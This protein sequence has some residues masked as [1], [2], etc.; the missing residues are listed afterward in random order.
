MAI[1]V[2]FPDS[3]INGEIFT[4]PNNGFT[5]QYVTG[6]GWVQYTA[7]I[8]QPPF[9]GTPT[10]I[11]VGSEPVN[12]IP[13]IVWFPTGP[14]T[15]GIGYIW[16]GS[17]WAIINA[18]RVNSG[19]ISERPSGP[20][21]GDLFF[22]TG[23]QVMELWD[24][25]SWIGVPTTVDAT[26]VTFA[27]GTGLVSS[28]VK[29]AIDEVDTKVN[30]LNTSLVY[31]GTYN[32]STN[33]VSSVTVGGTTA[34]LSTG[35]PL[36]SSAPNTF[37]IV[38]VD[39]I[40]TVPAPT[41]ALVAGN[42]LVNNGTSWDV[43]QF[44]DPV[45]SANLVTFTPTTGVGSTNVQAAVE[46]LDS[47]KADKSISIQAGTGLVGG[48]DLSA[49]STISLENTSVSSGSYGGQDKTI[50]IDVDPQGRLNS[51]NQVNLQPAT[52]FQAGIVQLDNSTTSV[53]ETTSP[54]SKALS[55]TKTVADAAL[56]QSVVNDGD[57]GDLASLVTTD[58]STIVNAINEVQIEADTA[59]STANQGV[60]DASAAQT[61][62]N[63]ADAKASTNEANIGTLGNL[64]TTDKSNVVNAINELDSGKAE[65]SR[66]VISGT[67][68]TGG[69]DLT[70]DR[71]LSLD[72][73]G[74]TAGT[75][76]NDGI[77]PQVQVDAYGR[78]TNISDISATLD[79][80]SNVSVAAPTDGQALVWGNANSQW[81]P[82]T[83]SNSI[84]T[85]T[86][87]ELN[88]A[89]SFIT[90]RWSTVAIVANNNSADVQGEATIFSSGDQ[91]LVYVTDSDGS[92]FK[93]DWD[94]AVAANGGSTF[95]LTFYVSRD[96]G[97]NWTTHTSGNSIYQSSFNNIQ[98]NTCN[99]DLSLNTNELSISF[100]NPSLPPT[101][102]ANG[103]ILRYVAAESV[104]KPAVLPNVNTTESNLIYVDAD[105]GN[106]TTGSVGDITL[107]YATI[108]AAL[109]AATSTS[110][111][112]VSE[113]TYN[114]ANPL[115][116]PAGVQIIS[117][118]GTL[119]WVNTIVDAT[120]TSDDVFILQGNGAGICGL[121][122]RVP[123]AANKA[124]ISY[125]GGSGTTASVTFT[126]FYGRAIS[127]G[128]AILVNS[129]GS[130]KIISFENRYRGL[131]M[132]CMMQVNGGIL[133]NESV[134]IPNTPLGGG[135]RTVFKN[136][137][138][139]GSTISRLQ[140]NTSNTGNSNVQHCLEVDGGTSVF[141]GINWFNAANG[142]HI[143]SDTYDVEISNGLCDTTTSVT[144]DAG[145]T[146]DSGRLVIF[147]FMNNEF[148][149]PNTWA[150]SDF[151][152]EFLTKINDPKIPEKSK[153]LRGADLSI[154]STT[155][156]GGITVGSGPVHKNGLIVLTSDN[157]A[158]STSDGG[159][160][161]NVTNEALSKDGSLFTFQGVGANHCIYFGS[162]E[163]SG[164]GSFIKHFGL[165]IEINSGDSRDGNYIFEIWDGAQ[166]ASFGAQSVGGES[167]FSYA[168]SHF[169]RNTS[170]E[171]VFYGLRPEDSWAVKAINGSN[172]Y[173]SRV[174]I[175]T[176]P[177][178]V[179]TFEQTFLI[180][181]ASLKVSK[182]G[183]IT[184]L[185][186][187]QPLTVLA[188]GSNIFSENGNVTDFTFTMGDGANSYDHTIDN[189]VLNAVGEGL[190]W[191]TTIAPG[192]CTAH[193]LYVDVRYSLS[194]VT[195]T[196]PE[197]RVYFAPIQTSGILIADPAGSLTPIPRP[198]SLTVPFTGAGAANPNLI[199]NFVA[200]YVLPDK[201]HRARLGPF[202]IENY[203]EGDE[204]ALEIE[205]E[206]RGSPQT[207]FIIWGVSVVGYQW[208]TGIR[209]E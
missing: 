163:L 208:T 137:N 133:A 148:S 154:G 85:A 206:D 16:D 26:G 92:D 11:F 44:G 37:V 155:K 178:S 35:S 19:L 87:F 114:E 53:S 123:S 76:G 12:P 200:P 169:W 149:Y 29:A 25:F 108:A 156:G 41:T 194:S 142:V 121:T 168:D 101:P 132:D 98:F 190:Y 203:Y 20:T 91:F 144:V 110:T 72:V 59:Q 159:N 139:A 78:I 63:T 112:V 160:I 111:I 57:I 90:N 38:T 21:I 124:A 47:E 117:K 157:T 162:D 61:T 99:P 75:Y 46:E 122:V 116:V 147:A 52:T 81:E 3:P 36:P 197:F 6:T 191:Q 171:K 204:V 180:P 82:G 195:T 30:N 105:F 198:E 136:T 64:T 10:G 172:A 58:H 71:T 138:S 51:V 189:V 31:G 94:A 209:G 28:D 2:N 152:F 113:G 129:T 164:S 187:A 202:S 128:I 166:W 49:S 167:G 193:P 151:T 131:N 86:D 104:F 174:R 62:A 14:G 109:S 84:Q 153:V 199:A 73:S 68:L 60:S 182:E 181:P 176:P 95:N 1:P 134:H 18:G 74:A 186:G 39:G 88:P 146:G 69:G 130:G 103:D 170:T 179:P 107:P 66:Q 65:S 118:V 7:A 48:G 70:A 115:N 188:Q 145:L 183:I 184:Q 45:T 161:T 40:G 201:L 192:T 127:D 5:L 141:Y 173:W 15:L 89:P 77:I 32:A 97:S 185:G 158:N 135:P 50:L 196:P 34:G 27:S 56:A 100:Q 67:G 125:I 150:D 165:E 120:N 8:T 42:W 43:L 175:D 119:G 13:G 55:D 79:G 80:L 126:G 22:N 106:D 140:C 24:G 143:T 207:D 54:T 33:L 177:T 4:N 17:E 9:S 83:L 102:L 96:G 93:G 23:T 205:V